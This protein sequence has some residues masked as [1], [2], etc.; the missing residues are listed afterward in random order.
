MSRFEIGKSDFLLDGQP[1]RVLS[2]AIHYFR[3]PKEYW[4]DRL[5]KAR[6]MGLNTIETYVPWN[7]HEPLQGTWVW[8]DN[9][10]LAAF[11]DAIADE[12]MRAIVRPGPFI[13]AEFDGGGLPAWLFAGGSVPVRTGHPGYLEPVKTYLSQVYDIIRPRQIEG[14]G[15]VILVQIE[16]EYGAY[17]SDHDYLRALTE[18]TRTAGITVPLT[19][20]D[21]PRDGMLEAG[22]LP[23]LLTT[24]SF[25]S[26]SRERLSEL[27]RVQPEG[28]LMC[29]EFWDG[30]FDQW[31]DYHHTT[32]ADD[33]AAELRE[34]LEAGASV[35][36][37]MFHG[38]TNFGFTN[39][40][41]DK[42]LYRPLV[43]SYDYDA[44][45]DEAGQPT[46]KYWALRE[47]LSDFADLSDEVPTKQPCAQ[48]LSG[49]FDAQVPLS[50]VAEC[51]GSWSEHDA[52]PTMDSLGKYRGFA[53]YKASLPA[54]ADAQILHAAE[55]R[56]R[57]VVTVDGDRVG[58]LERMDHDTTIALPPTTDGALLTLL[59]EDQGRV[60]YGPRIGEPKGLIGPVTVGDR[61]VVDWS[62]LPLN[63][64]DLDPVR[65]AL[66]RSGEAPYGVTEPTFLHA[67]F[68]LEVV[69]D[70]FLDVSK[71]AHGVVWVNGHNI[72]R[73]NR[74]GP[75][76]TMY[77]PA[78]FLQDGPNEL[79]VLE[80]D[81]ATDP[82]WSF[83]EGLDLGPIDW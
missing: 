69:G 54:H 50:E 27:R 6:L 2:G 24:G 14:G 33:S 48:V 67:T 31:S 28:P 72:G 55:V 30:W 66:D 35:N 1:Y 5:R 3:V 36:I 82:T 77:V 43:T 11:L 76:R 81:E 71:W 60:N 68:T 41:N 56:D 29:S 45:L 74:R 9:L 13:C 25:G 52:V 79:L 19:T 39:G 75:T 7:L 22:T 18:H 4:K 42:G 38:G 10:D 58:V 21:Q 8:E 64:D 65:D 44:P 12:G 20:V 40:A 63:L 59:I 51:L 62:A 37:Y 17:G 46:E 83:V 34:L 23:E 49:R 73:Y 80:V 26:R 47:V 15:P 32:S 57:A 78:P 61:P 70:L 53:L 16:N